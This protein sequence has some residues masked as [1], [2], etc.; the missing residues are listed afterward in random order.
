[1]FKDSPEAQSS[2]FEVVDIAADTRAAMRTAERETNAF[3]ASQ[4]VLEWESFDEDFLDCFD[5]ALTER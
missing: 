5:K 2:G 1:M 3:R 4:E